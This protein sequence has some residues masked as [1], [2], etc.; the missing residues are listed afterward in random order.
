MLKMSHEMEHF[1]EKILKNWRLVQ[2]VCP[3]S[4]ENKLSCRI[5]FVFVLMG[6][7]LLSNALRPFKTYCD[8]PNLDITRT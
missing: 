5:V 7:S 2:I 8:P 1:S 4:R 6:W 3:Q